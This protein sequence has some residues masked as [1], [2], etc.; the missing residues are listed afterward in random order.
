MWITYSKAF[1]IDKMISVTL[2]KNPKPSSKGKRV[3]LPGSPG[4]N[5]AQRDTTGH[6][7]LVV[8][9]QNT[10]MGLSS[11]ATRFSVYVGGDYNKD[12]VNDVLIVAENDS[13]LF[14][15]AAVLSRA[16][17]TSPVADMTWVNDGC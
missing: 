10:G 5:N 6:Y 17:L 15:S 2:A 12:G 3:L 11:Q 8:D 4:T 7:Q 13:V 9:G 16:S 14:K 1:S